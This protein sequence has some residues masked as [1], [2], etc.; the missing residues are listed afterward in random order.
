M[1]FLLL[2]FILQ[3]SEENTIASSIVVLL[4]LFGM[5][6]VGIYLLVD[7]LSYYRGK[8]SVSVWVPVSLLFVGSL[9]L[10]VFLPWFLLFCF[11]TNRRHRGNTPLTRF[12]TP[13]ELHL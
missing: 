5:I 1:I 3:P 6:G 8:L 13:I 9:G 11:R 12:Q 4:L 10:S 7:H 2:I